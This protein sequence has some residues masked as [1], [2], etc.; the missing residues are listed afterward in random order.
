MI[1]RI[2]GILAQLD[3]ESNTVILEVGDIGYELMVPGYAVCDL[4]G[5][6]QRPITLYC[7]EYYE[8]SSAGGNLVPRIVGFPRALDKDFFR[9]FLSVKGIGIRKALRALARPLDQIAAYIESGDDKMLAT[10]PEIGKRTAVQIIAELRGKMGDFARQAARIG[11]ARKPLSDMEREALEILLQ[12]GERPQDA[13]D[14]IGRAVQG[15]D[16]IA[17]TDALIQAVY[18]LKA[19]AIAP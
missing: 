14:L 8:G 12:L 1:A 3:T 10:L 17:T 4:S 16:N 11:A 15:F 9:R 5:Q 19:G 6:I 18:R 2:T 7:L 13:E